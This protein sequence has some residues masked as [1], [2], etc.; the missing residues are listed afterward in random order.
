MRIA[1]SKGYCLTAG[2]DGSH[3]R[4]AVQVLHLFPVLAQDQTL[5]VANAQSEQKHFVHHLKT[6]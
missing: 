3:I 1:V 2:I 6:E 5:L 4:E